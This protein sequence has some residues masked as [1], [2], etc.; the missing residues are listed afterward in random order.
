M[1][2]G[3]GKCILE[4]GLENI[5]CAFRITGLISFAAAAGMGASINTIVDTFRVRCGGCKSF[6]CEPSSRNTFGSGAGR[7]T[8][9]AGCGGGGGVI[10]MTVGW[11]TTLIG[12]ASSTDCRQG[13]GV[14]QSFKRC[15]SAFRT[16]EG[17]QSRKAR[18]S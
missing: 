5:V 13:R 17:G 18:D 16:N 15:T 7:I 4:G 14:S 6:V 11:G 3:A 2:V 1:A 9:C 12:S 8:S 10:C